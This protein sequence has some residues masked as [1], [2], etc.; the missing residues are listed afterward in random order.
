MAMHIWEEQC[1]VSV[2]HSYVDVTIP[3]RPIRLNCRPQ[4]NHSACIVDAFICYSFD[5]RFQG[6]W[7]KSKTTFVVTGKVCYNLVLPLD[8]VTFTLLTTPKYVLACVTALPLMNE[9]EGSCNGLI[10]KKVE[11]CHSVISPK[12]CRKATNDI[13]ILRP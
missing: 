4:F 9:P 6:S 13:G 11:L 8:V 12:K 2:S 1:H 7:E 10:E 5:V 3:Y